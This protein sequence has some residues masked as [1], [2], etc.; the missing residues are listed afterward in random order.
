MFFLTR[1]IFSGFPSDVDDVLHL[2]LIGPGGDGDVL[3]SLDD[4]LPPVLHDGLHDGVLLAGPRGG[5]LLAVL[6]VATR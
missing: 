6:Q 3:P 2:L 5:E 1:L 4:E